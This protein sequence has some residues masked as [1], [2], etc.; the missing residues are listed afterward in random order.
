MKKFLLILCTLVLLM[1]CALP[2]FAANAVTYTAV[3]QGRNGELTIETDILENK[4]M[5]V[6]VTNHSESAG[7]AD[8]AI[9]MMPVRI[10]EKQSVA[11]DVVSGATITS[12]AIAN[13]VS[14][15]IA[16]AGLDAVNYQGKEVYE[17]TEVEIMTGVLV[18][19]GGGSGLSAAIEAR[20]QGAD[21]L[22]LERL[23]TLGGNTKLSQ[24]M[25]LRGRMADEDESAMTA[26][27]VYR[28]FSN[29]GAGNEG[30][31]DAMVLEFTQKMEENTAWLMDMGYDA[32]PTVYTGW[33]PMEVGGNAEDVT[34]GL[35]LVHGEPQKG[36]SKGNYI[37]DAMQAKAEKVGVE[38]MVDTG[39]IELMTDD[40]GAV[41]GAKAMGFATN[42]EYTIH[43]SAVIIATGNKDG[44][45][46]ITG[47]T[48]YEDNGTALAR[49]AGAKI[50]VYGKNDTES[51]YIDSETR[52]I[53]EAGE[54][55]KHLYAVGEVT[56]IVSTGHCY[57]M[58]GARNAWSLFTGR[59]AGANAAA[60]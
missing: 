36:V 15:C 2:A 52:V 55:L 14:D 40:T 26:E 16:Q 58:C 13:A 31:N 27:E 18:I 46:G 59:I 47:G 35:V 57:T 30:F 56:E 51:I 53:N 44:N 22:L 7:V 5:A 9:E 34:K 60:E 48:G 3:A 19:G 50:G 38:I 54:T 20:E 10:V 45:D 33:L 12:N 8:P 4:I 24:G 17:R 42:T 39:A 29:Y 37:I 23:S 49:A 21:V 1:M 32:Q 11:A 43:A 6:R 41:V 28:Q 25:V